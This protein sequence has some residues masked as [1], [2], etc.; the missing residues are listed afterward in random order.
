M[1]VRK[2]ALQP[3]ESE[4]LEVCWAELGYW[5]AGPTLP[6]LRRPS[7]DKLG[8]ETDGRRAEARFKVQYWERS[9]AS[10][11]F[12]KERG[13]TRPNRACSFVT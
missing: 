7:E 9:N 13:N 5:A 8:A 12:A 11:C 10:A 2:I 6:G 1:G 3:A 4:Q